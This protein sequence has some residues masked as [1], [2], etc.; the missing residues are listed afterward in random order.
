MISQ[1][2]KFNKK[3]EL[4][5]TE[6]MLKESKTKI[7]LIK[8]SIARVRNENAKAGRGKTSI[9]RQNFKAFENAQSYPV[10]FYLGDE[11]GSQSLNERIEDIKHRIC[12]EWRIAEGARNMMKLPNADK[13]AMNETKERVAEC[14]RKLAILKYSLEK[15]EFELQIVEYGHTAPIPTVDITQIA[16]QGA[17]LPPD[18][19]LYRKAD[20]LTGNLKIQ[21]LGMTVF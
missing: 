9:D 12:V 3:Q 11:I 1:F 2:K 7:E 15:R 14:E 19:N 17:T 6:D 20:P 13:K 10:F 21:L 5:E 4:F 8:M 16:A 18:S